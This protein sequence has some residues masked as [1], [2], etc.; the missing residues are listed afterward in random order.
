MVIHLLLPDWPL[1]FQLCRRSET[2]Q[3]RPSQHLSQMLTLKQAILSSFPFLFP[4][5]SSHS[6]PYRIR[7]KT[8]LCAQRRLP[9]RLHR[10]LSS[11]VLFRV[12]LLRTLGTDTGL[13]WFRVFIVLS[14][15]NVFSFISRLL[16]SLQLFIFHNLEL[17]LLSFFILASI[18]LFSKRSFM[19]LAA[20]FL[21]LFLQNHSR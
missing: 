21:F 2:V 17:I 1:S 16:H 3:T 14:R 8:A 6:L 18:S 5:T 10:L 7:W 19:C 13:E 15:E 9:S 20:F 12:P 4:Q 11:L